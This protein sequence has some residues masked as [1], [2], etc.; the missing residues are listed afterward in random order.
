MC[1]MPPPSIRGAYERYVLPVCL[2]LVQL[3]GHLAVGR[4]LLRRKPRAEQEAGER[5]SGD[6]KGRS[7][8]EGQVVTA[9]QRYELG[10]AGVA[11]VTRAPIGKAGEA[12]F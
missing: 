3:C 1:R 2:V 8:D 5:R 9:G 11:Q 7:D 12:L 10:R 4:R 6:R